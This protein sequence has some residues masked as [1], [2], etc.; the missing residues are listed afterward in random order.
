MP[1]V[2]SKVFK[3]GLSQTQSQ[4]L[5]QKVTEVIVPLRNRSSGGPDCSL[6]MH[7]GLITISD[8]NMAETS[9]VFLHQRTSRQEEGDDRSDHPSRP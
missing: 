8:L 2:E 3:G 9:A 1:L 6:C 7:V 4:E 5:I